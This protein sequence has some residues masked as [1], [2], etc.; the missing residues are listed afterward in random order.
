MCH[1][2]RQFIPERMIGTAHAEWFDMLVKEKESKAAR[3][4]SNFG[5]LDYAGLIQL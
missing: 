3:L 4:R 2:D 1:H 5:S